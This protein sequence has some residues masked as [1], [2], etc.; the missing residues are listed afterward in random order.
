[1]DNV[2][3]KRAQKYRARVW[4]YKALNLAGLAILGLEPVGLLNL[5]NKHGVMSKN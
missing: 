4:Q 5:A 2:E 1:M 3:R